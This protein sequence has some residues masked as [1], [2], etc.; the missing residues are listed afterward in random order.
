MGLTAGHDAFAG[1]N[2]SGV[3]KFIGKVYSNR[4]HYF[5]YATAALGGG[6]PGISLLSTLPVPG[7]PGGMEWSVTLGQPIID[8]TPEDVGSSLPAPLT[9]GPNQFSLA[10]D[11]RLCVACGLRPKQGPQDDRPI[12]RP[13]RRIELTCANIRIWAVGEPTAVPAGI[14][15][16]VG[17]HVDEIVVK[18]V[19]A[20]EPLIECVATEAVNAM[21]D[22]L[23]QTV[24]TLVLHGF[25]LTLVAGPTIA[26]DQLEVWG[27]II[28]PS[29]AMA[30]GLDVDP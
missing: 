29:V 20:L 6:S 16:V 27:T 14:D 15:T 12:N 23:K 19:G 30:G 24:T 25:G 22:N 4:P 18:D 11:A 26:D 8:F 9:V 21:L 7:V 3:N 13:P 2:E 1:L 10:V 17:L 28:P 5:H